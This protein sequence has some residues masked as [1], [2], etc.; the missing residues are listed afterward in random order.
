[1]SRNRSPPSAARLRTPLCQFEFAARD[2]LAKSVRAAE[3]IAMHVANVSFPRKMYLSCFLSVCLSVSILYPLTHC[4][5]ALY[6]TK[7]FFLFCLFVCLFLFS[8]F[9]T[10]Y[11]FYTHSLFS[12]FLIEK[13]FS[14]SFV[15]SFSHFPF[16]LNVSLS[17]SFSLSVSNSLSN[18]LCRGSLLISTFKKFI[19][20]IE[21]LRSESIH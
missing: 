14:F 8:L 12:A 3:E 7:S 13:L 5:L 20:F 2:F 21:N 17:F 9:H 16:I 18:C 6:S 1:M 10:Y 15:I 19:F 4:P 11:L